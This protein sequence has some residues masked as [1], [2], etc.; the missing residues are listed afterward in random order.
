MM[1]QIPVVPGETQ[2]T[3]LARIP[4]GSTVE[5]NNAPAHPAEI[6][7]WV[8]AT[9]KNLLAIVLMVI[10]LIVGHKIV[11]GINDLQQVGTFNAPASA[12]LPVDKCGGGV[13]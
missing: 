12:T 13:C 8:F 2:R 6:I 11:T 5:V 9:I 7:F 1:R 4:A 3:M 10:V